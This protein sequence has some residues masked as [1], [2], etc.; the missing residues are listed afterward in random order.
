[1]TKAYEQIRCIAFLAGSEDPEP[2]ATAVL[3]KLADMR[4]RYTLVDAFLALGLKV[5]VRVEELEG[6]VEV[7]RHLVVMVR[8]VGLVGQAGTV[9]KLAAMERVSG[10][11]LAFPLHIHVK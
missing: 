1:M 8:V 9:H 2:V 10:Q 6:Q 5:V 4:H 3:G 11:Q 7:A